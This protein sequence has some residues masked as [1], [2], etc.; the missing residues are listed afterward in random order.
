VELLGRYSNH[1]ILSKL[2]QVVAG[3]G[4]DRPSARTVRSHQLQHRLKPDET[5]ELLADYNV[6]TTIDALA[7]QFRVNRTTVLSILDRAGAE[8]RAGVIDRNLDE[9]RRLYESGS[10]LAQVGQHFDVDPETV[11]RALKKNGVKMRKSWK[12]G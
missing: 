9:A 4:R 8:R 11:R 10:S 5:N 6:G 7:E 1:D 12:R 2:R 3:D